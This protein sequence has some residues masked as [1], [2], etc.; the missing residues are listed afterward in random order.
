MNT[1]DLFRR[2]R[3]QRRDFM[4]EREQR[5][6]RFLRTLA[7]LPGEPVPIQVMQRQQRKFNP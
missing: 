1:Q 6:T 7:G 4:A 5:W 2:R 3:H